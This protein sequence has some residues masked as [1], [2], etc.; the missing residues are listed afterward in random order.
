MKRLAT[1]IACGVLA[2]CAQMQMP[3]QLGQILGGL[4]KPAGP[5]TV[6]SFNVPG[7][8][9]AARDAELTSVLAKAGALA[10]KQTRPAIVIVSAQPAQF[11]YLTQAIQQGIPPQRAASVAVNT[12]AA[13]VDQPATV[14]IQILQ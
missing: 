2:G 1:L 14:T 11:A 4:T 7:D 13:A 9:I 6:M 3:G 10:G 12:V 5:A 8:A